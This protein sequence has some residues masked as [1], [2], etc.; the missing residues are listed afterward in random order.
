MKNQNGVKKYHRVH[1]FLVQMMFQNTPEIIDFCY[2][3]SF[4][5]MYIIYTIHNKMTSTAITATTT[6]MAE[7]HQLGSEAD[8]FEIWIANMC[9]M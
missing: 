4:N 2:V 8:H 7:H 1:F 5:R 3:L 9:Y 6:T